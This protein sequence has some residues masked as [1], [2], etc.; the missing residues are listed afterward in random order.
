[1]LV[2]IGNPN[3]TEPNPDATPG[4]PLQGPLVTSMPVPDGIYTFTEGDPGDVAE[5]VRAGIAVH[6]NPIMSH[7]P[8]HELIV[9]IVQSWDAGHST[10]GPSFVAVSGPDPDLAAAV[11]AALAA[12]W[13]CPAGLPDD[14]EETHWTQYGTEVFPPGTAPEEG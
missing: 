1:M 2:E 10:G 14:L 12:Y 5:E 3:P 6:A 13:S 9:H 11:E 4:A 7:A 8:D